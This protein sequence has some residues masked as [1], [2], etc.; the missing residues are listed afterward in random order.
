MP[1]IGW[2]DLTETEMLNFSIEGSGDVVT[3][4]TTNITHDGNGDIG[5][6]MLYIYNGSQSA[7]K[8]SI[9]GDETLLNGGGTTLTG[10]VTEIDITD[11]DIGP[12]YNAYMLITA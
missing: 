11:M 6:C 8:G 7:T 4:N 3:I 1:I 9:D 12:D 2:G 10:A 5:D